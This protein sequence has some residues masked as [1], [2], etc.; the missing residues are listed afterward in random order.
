MNKAIYRLMTAGGA[1]TVLL[2]VLGNPITQTAAVLVT[3]ALSLWAQECILKTITGK[4]GK[5]CERT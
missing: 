2:T 3:L 5:T 1:T 4:E